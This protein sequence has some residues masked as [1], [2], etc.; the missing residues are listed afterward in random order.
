LTI[1]TLQAQYIVGFKS[2]VTRAWEEN[3]N[4]ERPGNASP[5]VNGFQLSTLAYYK[6]TPTIWLGIEPGYVQRGAA[7]R[8]GFLVFDRSTYLRTNYVELPLFL[9][10]HFPLFSEK[11]FLRPKLGIGTSIV[12]SAFEDIFSSTTGRKIRRTRL[13]FD[14]RDPIRR[15]DSGLYGGL[16]L[17]ADLGHHQI[18]VESSY[19]HGIPDVDF[20]V[21]SRN[22]SLQIKLGFM[23]HL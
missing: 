8:P 12:V 6:I 17:S 16:T 5:Y 21:T 10:A 23:I 22:R 4:V 11:V 3:G 2:G 20:I 15:W 9:A 1:L 13:Y 18:I 7:R 14:G 19:Y